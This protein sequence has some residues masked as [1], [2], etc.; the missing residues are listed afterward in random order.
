MTDYIISPK[1]FPS[2]F[3]PERR[4]VIT[5]HSGKL[6]DDAQGYGYKTAQKAHK[7]AWYRFKGG[8]RKKDTVKSAAQAFWSRNKEYVE[9]VR[10]EAFYAMKDGEDDAALCAHLVDCFKEKGITDFKAAYLEYLP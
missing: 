8:K 2:E 5:D 10:Y 7:A 6:L 1:D 9:F 4:Y 3:G